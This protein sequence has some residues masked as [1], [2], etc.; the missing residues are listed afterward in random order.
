MA[1]NQI[2]L[3]HQSQHWVCDGTFQFRPTDFN[4]CQIYVVFGAVETEWHPGC[5]ALMPNR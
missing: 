2:D 3:L 1:P 4:F 5:I